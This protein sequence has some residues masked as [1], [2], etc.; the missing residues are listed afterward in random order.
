[1]LA[2]ILIGLSK[3]LMFREH[4]IQIPELKKD[5][6]TCNDSLYVTEK[7]IG[8]DNTTSQQKYA[9]CRPWSMKNRFVKILRGIQWL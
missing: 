2:F 5:S 9:H 4:V 8:F 3:V 1:V 6:G 7:S